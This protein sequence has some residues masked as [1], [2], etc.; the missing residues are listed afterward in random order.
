MA[1]AQARLAASETQKS[2][3]RARL[4]VV[5][6]IGVIVAVAILCIVVAVLT[7]AQRADEVALAQEK[8]LFTK[9]IVNHGERVLRELES[10]AST[11]GAVTHIRSNFNRDWIQDHV[12]LR[13]RS[14]FDHDFVFVA[15]SSDKLVYALLG[16]S[17]VEPRWF[18]SILPELAPT[19]DYVRGRSGKN[20]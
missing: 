1:A 9:S 10:V 11:D 4:S 5:I 7:S 16:H 8:R 20:P 3:D 17:S 15:D 14:F 18:N 13:L 12:G 19:V 6:P 2:W